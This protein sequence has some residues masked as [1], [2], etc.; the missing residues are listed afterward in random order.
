VL[1]AGRKLLAADPPG[2]DRAGVQVLAYIA[3]QAKKLDKFLPIQQQVLKRNPTPQTYKEY[4]ALL[5]NLKK[6]GEAAT[7]LNE[8]FGKYPEERNARQVAEQSRLY[9]LADKNEEAVRSAREALKLDPNDMDVRLQAALVLSQAGKVE[10]A[11]VLLREVVK[12][13]PANPAPSLILGGILAQAGQNEEATT[14]FKELLEKFPNNDDVVRT[15]RSN[16]SIIYVNQGDYAK[17]EAELELLLERNPDEPGVNNDLGYLYADQGKNLEKAESMIR[18]ALVE[19]PDSAAY[20]DSLGWVLFKR[21]KVK[22]AVEPLERAVK[23]LAE[24]PGSGDAT[25]FEHLGDVYFQLQETARAKAAW[26]TA[27]TSAAKANPPDK[28]LPEIRKKLESLDKLGQVPKTSAGK[29][30]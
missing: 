8:L 10:E 18:K 30:P 23:L 11:V 29:T 19:D 14:L 20:L 16:L 13:D 4:L 28:R 26:K 12:K 21:G 22:E 27:E 1:E 2:L 6:Y 17:G 24:T 15:A 25:I 3:N 5:S 7:T 9:R